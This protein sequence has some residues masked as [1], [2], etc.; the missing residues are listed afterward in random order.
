MEN[1]GERRRKIM[2]NVAGY[3]KKVHQSG[4]MVK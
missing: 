2:K 3:Q 1:N 4:E